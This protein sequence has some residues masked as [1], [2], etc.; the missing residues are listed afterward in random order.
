[1]GRQV[2]EYSAPVRTRYCFG[3]MISVWDPKREP[4]PKKN[5]TDAK[6]SVRAAPSGKTLETL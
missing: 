3:T 4:K 6:Y 2:T 5:Q 1:M